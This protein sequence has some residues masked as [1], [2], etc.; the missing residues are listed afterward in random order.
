M[1]LGAGVLCAQDMTTTQTNYNNNMQNNNNNRWFYS[2]SSQLYHDYEVSLEGFA[3]GTAQDHPHNYN[4]FGHHF[5]DGRVGGGA[6]LELFFLRYIGVEAEGF[7]Q[8]TRPDFVDSYGANLVLRYPIGETG[9]APYIF[10]GGGHQDDPTSGTYADGGAGVEYRF[11]H[12]FGVF[13]D[14]RFVSSDKT[15]R[16]GEGRLGVKFTF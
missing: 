8:G 7:S 5:N 10:G 12:C 16:S 11:V 14:G 15:G 13:V 4:H 6:G 9:F 3:T 2:D 1:F